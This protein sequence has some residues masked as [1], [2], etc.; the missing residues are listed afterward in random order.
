MASM[1]GHVTI[2][3][4]KALALQVRPT[5]LS[6]FQKRLGTLSAIGQVVD[7]DPVLAE[8][9]D[10]NG[11]VEELFRYCRGLPHQRASMPELEAAIR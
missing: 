3:R 7:A 8:I 4:L 6:A 9:L 10:I 2:E 11:L 5:Q 1:H